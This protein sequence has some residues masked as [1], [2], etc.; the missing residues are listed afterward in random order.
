[1]VFFIELKEIHLVGLKLPL[2]P[3]LANL[4]RGDGGRVLF[5]EDRPVREERSYALLFLYM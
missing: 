1:M 4:G 5:S 3:R 2:A